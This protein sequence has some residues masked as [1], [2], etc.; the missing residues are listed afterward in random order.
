[1]IR[2][3]DTPDEVTI[4]MESIVKEHFPEL[5]NAKIKVIFDTKKR[6]YKGRLTL[7]RIQATSEILKH[8][9]I[10]EANSEDGYDYLMYLDKVIYENVE[11]K[12]RIRLIRHELRHCETDM[13]AAKPYKLKDHDINDFYAEIELNSDDPHWAEKCI[14]IGL[15]L[16]DEE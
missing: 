8:L 4:L 3:E 2:F 6:S 5:V 11:E 12:D 13:E 1:M 7:G 15:S 10:E 9:T 16:Y 14:E